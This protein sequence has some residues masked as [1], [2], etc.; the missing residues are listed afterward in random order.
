MQQLLSVLLPAS[1]EAPGRARQHLRRL[2]IRCSRDTQ[3]DALLLTSELIT[4]AVRHAR[5]PIRL[6]VYCTAQALRIAVSDA[7]PQEL[8]LP[9][10]RDELA[11]GGRGL[12]I[13]QSIADTWGVQSRAEPPGK[14]VWFDLFLTSDGVR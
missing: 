2:S 4:N 14:T 9:E 12:H 8:V 7:G 10:A 1:L 5:G 6:A 3:D 11:T 13:L